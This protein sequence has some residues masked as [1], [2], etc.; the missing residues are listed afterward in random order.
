MKNSKSQIFNCGYSKGFSVKDVINEMEK[1][2]KKKIPTKVGKRRKG[3][4]ERVVADVS[5]FKK[6]FSWKP[7]YNKM[8]LILSSALEWEYKINE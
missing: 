8:K 7:K 6:F 2:I 3:D 4:S 5:K 1:I